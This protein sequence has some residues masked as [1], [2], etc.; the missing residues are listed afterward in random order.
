MKIL[1]GLTEIRQKFGALRFQHGLASISAVL[2]RAGYADISLAA[3]AEEPDA[4]AWRGRLKSFE[5][6]VVAF[7]STAE[8]FPYVRKLIEQVPPG[9]FII[10]GGPH[11]SCFP[12]CIETVPRLDAVCIGEGEYPM[13]DLVKALESGRDHTHI[14]NLWVRHN[15]QII[16]NPCRPFI[17][18]LDELPYEDYELFNVQKSIDQYGMSQLRFLTSRSC[19]FEC[20]YC[21]NKQIS[22]SQPGKYVRFRSAAHVLGELKQLRDKYRFDEI[23]FDDDIF[24]MNKGIMDEFCTRYPAEIGKPFVFCGRVEVC[25]PE[26]LARLKQAG[27]RRIDFGLESGNEE[28]RRA[29]LKRRMTNQQIIEA[30][31]MAKAAGLQVKTLNMVGLPDETLEKHMD[32][33]RLNREIRP[34]VVGTFV[35]FPYPGTELHD[36]CVAKK[37]C[38]P[39]EDIPSG[40]VSR[41]QSVLNMPSFPKE[42]IERC[43]R[44][45][46]F[47][48][49]G[50][51]APL[52]ALGYAIIY[53]SY[54]ETILNATKKYRKVLRKVLKGF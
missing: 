42:Q 28:L 46:P 49:F 27:G 54:G 31:R 30:T 4:E 52:K 32:T 15:G 39:M 36:Y 21:S 23:F 11:T 20:T 19:P 38:T 44:L 10:C 51:Y 7:Y 14:Q 34:D 5:P 47:R 25:R 6:N 18:N 9:I 24:M 3:F 29:V 8:Q 26:M 1:L 53:S 13:L 48:V 12:S 35:F 17:E 22:K 45:F 33:V 40:Y 37:Y 43:F 41:R 50:T 2:K 16:K